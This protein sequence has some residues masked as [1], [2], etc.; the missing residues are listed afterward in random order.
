MRIFTQ[1]EALGE[2]AH[3]WCLASPTGTMLGRR[4]DVED[5]VHR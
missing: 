2:K 5:L 3:V 1:I 4:H